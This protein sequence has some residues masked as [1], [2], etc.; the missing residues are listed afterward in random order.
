LR[1]PERERF[2][3]ALDKLEAETRTHLNQLEVEYHNEL[4]RRNGRMTDDQRRT[5]KQDYDSK[6]I[7]LRRDYNGIM[8]R[9]EELTL[10]ADPPIVQL[11]NAITAQP[12]VKSEPTPVQQDTTGWL[13]IT[14]YADMY[15]IPKSTVWQHA[16]EGKLDAVLIQTPTGKQWRIK[17]P[18][19]PVKV[20]VTPEPPA[21]TP[22]IDTTGWLPIAEAAAL[23]GLSYYGLSEKLRKGEITGVKKSINGKPPQWLVKP[24]E[25]MSSP[26]PVPT[27]ASPV[28]QYEQELIERVN[29]ATDLGNELVDSMSQPL[30]TEGV[31]EMRF[32]LDF[33]PALW[34]IIILL[35]LIALALVYGQ[36]AQ[37]VY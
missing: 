37:Y 8:Q 5:L 26:E 18:A 10:P 31:Q 3:A 30:T 4:E 25:T 28:T 19:T 11:R 32:T 21:V 20:E 35:G 33:S 23:Y 1:G 17:P 2:A 12:E 29:R 16:N 34:L 15:H 24:P 13:S 6:L 27:V 9:L 22:E 14:V 7:P 36:V